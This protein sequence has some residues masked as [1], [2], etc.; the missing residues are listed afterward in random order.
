MARRTSRDRTVGTLLAASALA[1]CAGVAGAD[2]SVRGAA[3][4]EASHPVG[5]NDFHITYDSTLGPFNVTG[6]TARDNRGEGWTAATGA[7]PAG[8]PATARQTTFTR[9]GTANFSW[10]DVSIEI[11]GE[12][13][14]SMRVLEKFWTIGGAR[15]PQRVGGFG[16]LQD[17]DPTTGHTRVWVLN[18]HTDMTL[19]VSGISLDLFDEF[20]LPAVDADL[21]LSTAYSHS[22]ADAV[23]APGQGVSFTFPR[24]MDVGE[25][26][27]VQGRAERWEES[28]GTWE[29]DGNF[30][31][32]HEYLPP[33]PTP[34]SVAMLG[35][36]ALVAARRRR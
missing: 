31:Y 36:S 16:M 1:A 25:W 5:T 12:R 9:T 24:A 19:R 23:L 10:L 20:S 14:C 22:L 33:V 3:R 6:A 35:V 21:E 8:A 15:Q 34:G 30:R 29:P 26:S 18:D 32:Q 13:L 28:T 11:T 2:V 7:A 27:A 17:E 4:I